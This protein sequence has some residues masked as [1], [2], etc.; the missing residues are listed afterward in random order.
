MR[1]YSR[2]GSLGDEFHG[3]RPFGRFLVDTGDYIEGRGKETRKYECW[4]VRLPFWTLR[5]DWRDYGRSRHMMVP[6]QLLL[7]WDG[8][9]GLRVHWLQDHE[10]RQGREI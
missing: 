1:V 8:D 10:A 6:S 2:F 3:R 5:P 4:W 7:E 9:H